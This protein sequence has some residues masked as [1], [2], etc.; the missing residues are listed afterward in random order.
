MTA[1][2]EPKVEVLDWPSWLTIDKI[3]REKGIS[4]V[5]IITE[6]QN[7]FNECFKANPDDLGFLIDGIH[8]LQLAIENKKIHRKEYSIIPGWVYM[9]FDFMGWGAVG[10]GE[11]ELHRQ[12]KIILDRALAK[13]ELLPR[14]EN[15]QYIDAK[16]LERHS[17]HEIFN[18]Y[19][20]EE[21]IQKITYRVGHCKTRF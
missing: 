21:S 20:E 14:L 18:K 5:P 3:K 12:I 2:A 1:K 7:L 19:K 4:L 17:V 9:I 11:K 16:H 13:K 10:R 8:H 15:F 6:I